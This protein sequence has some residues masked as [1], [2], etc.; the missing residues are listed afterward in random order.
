MRIT[1]LYNP[2]SGRGRGPVEVAKLSAVLEAKG[3]EVRRLP[4]RPPGET[5]TDR[6]AGEIE[7]TDLLVVLGGDGA[8]RIAVPAAGRAGVPIYQFPMGTEN[9]FAKAFG[10]RR[11]AAALLSAIE[12][13]TI[14]RI[15]TGLLRCGDAVE[16]FTIMASIGFDSAVVHDLAAN[17]RGAITRWSY[18]RPILRQLRR[19]RPPRLEVRI[20]GEP[21]F[22]GRA[23]LMVANLP[24]YARG[25]DPAKWADP[26]DGELDAVVFPTAGSTDLFAWAALVATGL[27]LH[28]R[29]LI[30]RIGRR[31]EVESP[32]PVEVQLD[33]DAVADC[34]G[35]RMAFDAAPA[36]LDVLLPPPR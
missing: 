1:C 11:G 27:H 18:A 2:I 20:D 14:R 33:G 19:W 3:H 31:I 30:Y 13:W 10:M 4:T 6:L 24:D 23:F 34:T 22:S 29:R 9:L 5:E 26:S 8:V 7:G 36:S 28:D 21:I 32:G 12:A 35:S 25:L 17:R 16:R 15:D